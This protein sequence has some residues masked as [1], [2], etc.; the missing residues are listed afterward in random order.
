MRTDKG[1][2]ALLAYRSL[3]ARVTAALALTALAACKDGISLFE[4]PPPASAHERYANGLE[5]AG[6][7]QTPLG[8][9]WLSAA[10]AS[11]RQPLSVSLPFREAGYFAASEARAVAFAVRL[12]EGQRVS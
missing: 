5:K 10:A 6:L 3:L 7:H 12:R 4:P 8:R 11:I 9:D 1:H 2:L